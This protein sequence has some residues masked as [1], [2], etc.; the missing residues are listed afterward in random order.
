MYVKLLAHCMVRSWCSLT[1]FCLIYKIRITLALAWYQ[2]D[3]ACK[4]VIN[5]LQILCNRRCRNLYLTS[6]QA[7]LGAF[8][9]VCSF[10]K[11]DPGFFGC[12][13][14]WVVGWLVFSGEGTDLPACRM[15]R[16]TLLWPKNV[17]VRKID[18]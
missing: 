12:L 9:S 4:H 14:G 11:G 18:F 16:F 6:G 10:T 3:N 17:M 7:R 13:V 1:V 8:A 5:T 2:Q 15:C